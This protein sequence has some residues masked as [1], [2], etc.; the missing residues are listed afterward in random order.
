M[1]DTDGTADRGGAR[2]SGTPGPAGRAVIV[3]GGSRGLGRQTTLR[4]AAQGC[5]LAVCGRDAAS[6][7]AVAE[8]VRARYGRALHTARLDVLDESALAA[9]VRESAARFGRLDGLVTVAGG[10]RGAD[11]RGTEASDWDLTGRLNITHPAIALREAAD[12]LA[13]T[14]GSAVLVSSVSGW[15]PAPPAQ[16]AAAKAAQIH[17]AASLARELGP[18][19]VRVN[20]V[21]PGSMLIEGKGWARLRDE[22]P[23]AYREFEKEFPG[24]RLVDP[25]DVAEVIAFLLSDRARAVNG[26]N[27]PVDGGQN[28]PSA[29]GY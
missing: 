23:R 17:M 2:E 8:E 24:G 16:Y 22:D 1:N 29:Y 14:G 27:I 18:R 13:G 10:A 12:H 5:D 3:T 4:L 19:G 20:C 9:F 21:S 25:R 28:A 7:D 11:L 26:A 15:K 6:L